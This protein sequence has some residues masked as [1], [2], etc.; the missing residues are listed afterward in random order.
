MH[1]ESQNTIVQNAKNVI[2][3]QVHRVL[4]Y[5]LLICDTVSITKALGETANSLPNE[6]SS[7]Q[8]LF[9]KVSLKHQYIYLNCI[10]AYLP[11]HNNW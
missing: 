11:Q 2:Q 3:V 9:D 1:K 4:K 10:N 5:I 7:R 6:T 8:N